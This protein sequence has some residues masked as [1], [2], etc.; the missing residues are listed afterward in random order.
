MRLHAYFRSTA[1]YRVRIAL[2]I[3]IEPAC[4]ALPA[5]AEAAPER[6][7]DAR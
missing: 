3:E 7:T 6:R 4:L 1:S 5:F 2:K